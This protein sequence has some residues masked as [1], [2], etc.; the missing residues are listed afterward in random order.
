MVSCVVEEKIILV[1][2]LVLFILDELDLFV[3]KL[4]IKFDDSI[5]MINV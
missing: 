2:F 4:W 3:S 5:K 1:I